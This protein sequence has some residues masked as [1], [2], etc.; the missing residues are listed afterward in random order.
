MHPGSHARVVVERA[1][2]QA[3]P[4]RLEVEPAQQLRAAHPAKAA[5][6]SWRRFVPGD[7]L[8]ALH[9]PEVAHANAGPAAERCAMRL[10][11]HRAMAV[12]RAGERT[13]DLV[14]H[15]AAEATAAKH[16]FSSTSTKTNSCGFGFTTL[17]STPSGLAYD[18]P[19]ANSVTI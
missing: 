8:F 7:E 1:Q 2:R 4:F 19:I 5:M 11:A 9:P 15:A 10:A 13:G 3:V 6:R 14:S 16:Y 12:Q 18:W 17:C